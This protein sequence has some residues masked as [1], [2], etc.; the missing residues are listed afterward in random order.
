[1]IC[2]RFFHFRY[3]FPFLP[4][5]L[6]RSAFL[7]PLDVHRENHRTPSRLLA[8]SRWLCVKFS[9]LITASAKKLWLPCWAL[10]GLYSR[11]LYLTL[12]IVVSFLIVQPIFLFLEN[13]Y[14]SLAK[15]ICFF[16]K[17]Y[18]FSTAICR[19][20]MRWGV[21]RVVSTCW[22]ARNISYI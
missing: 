14:L 22:M 5:H 17:R 1:M 13:L 11:T 4:N 9:L 18:M 16:G 21:Y 12:L 20:I 2:H 19:V 10:V 8:S 7:S 3:N 6:C 15:G